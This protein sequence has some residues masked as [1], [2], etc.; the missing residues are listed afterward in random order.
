MAVTIPV[1]DPNWFWSPYSTE[2]NGVGA[3]GANNVRSD[4]TW[5]QWG[6]AGGYCALGF[7]GTSID[8]EMDTSMLTAAAVPTTK[9]PVI[10]YSIDGGTET[11][12]RLPATGTSLLSVTGLAAGNHTI[13]LL[14]E[15]AD[16]GSYD[17]WVTPANCARLTSA[18]VDVGASSVPLTGQLAPRPKNLLA[19]GDSI[20]E[21]LSMKGIGVGQ[22]A[23]SVWANF[24]AEALDA[25][26]GQIGCGSQGWTHT[27]TGGFVALPSSWDQYHGGASRLTG[28]LF[29]P[30]PDYIVNIHGANERTS[31]NGLTSTTV[32]D[33]LAAVRAAAPGAWIF[34]VMPFGDWATPFAAI[35]DGTNAYMSSS[36]DAKCKLVDLGADAAE[37]LNWA[38]GG[39]ATLWS[40]DGIHPGTIAHARIGARLAEQI[41]ALITPSGGKSGGRFS[42]LRI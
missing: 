1:T 9:W 5:A 20:L 28:G 35:Q 15:R 36:G 18:I 14:F 8:I 30:V 22:S 41:K 32:S 27:G 24:L 34:S 29:T 25:N 26:L 11:N 7:S 31:L 37:G 17:R 3:I 10:L 13:Y 6:L 23:Q 42:R 2:S 4:A 21:G 40:T 39:H 33:W 19:Y 16:V 38:A 12:V